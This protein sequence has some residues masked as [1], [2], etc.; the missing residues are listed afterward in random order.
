MTT[1]IAIALITLMIM[2]LTVIGYNVW[3]FGRNERVLRK[4]LDNQEKHI[5]RLTDDLSSYATENNRLNRQIN[6][7]ESMILR[8]DSPTG[9]LVTNGKV[10]FVTN[11]DL[12]HLHSKRQETTNTET[13]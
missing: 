2:N 13:N 7:L 10:S 4:D 8:G 3:V 12:E 1:L 5:K 9:L 6:V 11:K